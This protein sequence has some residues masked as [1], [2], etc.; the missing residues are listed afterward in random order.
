MVRIPVPQQAHQH[1]RE[2][3]TSP[4]TSQVRRKVPEEAADVEQFIDIRWLRKYRIANVLECLIKVVF[5][6]S[7]YEEWN[8]RVIIN[9]VMA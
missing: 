8:K 7:L 5:I 1:S 2:R 9:P 4:A 6:R 3:D